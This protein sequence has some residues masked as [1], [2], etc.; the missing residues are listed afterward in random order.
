MEIKLLSCLVII[1]LLFCFSTDCFV[2]VSESKKFQEL[3]PA[4][5]DLVS[6]LKFNLNFPYKNQIMID[7]FIKNI[8][9]AEKY[10]LPGN[11]LLKKTK[12]IEKDQ[13]SLSL[14]SLPRRNARTFFIG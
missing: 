2:L 11:L 8:L 13:L 10:K 7:S 14:E 1:S 12:D 6:H 9:K 5:G 4:V 3:K